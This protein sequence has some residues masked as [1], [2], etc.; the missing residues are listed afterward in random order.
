MWIRHRFNSGV[1]TDCE[2]TI[3]R[4]G[5]Y[6]N[7]RTDRDHSPCLDAD[8]S[9]STADSDGHGCPTDTDPVGLTQHFVYPAGCPGRPVRA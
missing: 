7:T 2:R 1:S 5:C 4:T 9:S 8:L 3:D 6:S